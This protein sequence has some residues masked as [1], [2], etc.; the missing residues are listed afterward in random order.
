MY[1]RDMGQTTQ[2]N[3]SNLE[4]ESVITSLDNCEI[5]KFS[6]ELV[7][8]YKKAAASGTVMSVKTG[9]P[10]TWEELYAHTDKWEATKSN[11]SLK[12]FMKDAVFIKKHDA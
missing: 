1:F 4:E 9:E 7:A 3:K 10:M 2:T 11:L 6:P 12:E 8:R 5:V